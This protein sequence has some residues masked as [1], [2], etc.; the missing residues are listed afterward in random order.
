MNILEKIKIFLNE[1]NDL[2]RETIRTL[3]RQINHIKQY[4]PKDPQLK[5]LRKEIQDLR[6]QLKNV[7]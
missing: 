3:Q 1:N 5:K 4:D 6:Q 7:D 2:K